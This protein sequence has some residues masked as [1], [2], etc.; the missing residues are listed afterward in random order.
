[1]RKFSLFASFVLAVPLAMLSQ[2]YRGA[3]GG[4]VTDPTGAVVTGAKVTVTETQTGTKVDTVS[5]NAG[6]YVAPFL[7]PGDYAIAVN[8]AGFKEFVR[9]GVHVGAGEHP[10]I[11]IRLEVG[12]ATQSVEVTADAGM[13]NTEN[14]SAGQAIS[15]REVDDLP[16]NGG[17]PL[18]MAALSLGVI[19]TGQPGLIHPF[20]SGGAA[21]WSV[22]GGYAQTSELL[23]DGSPDATWDGRLAYSLP[24]DAVEEV[25]I[26]A[27]DSDASYGHTGGGT[28]NQIMKTGTNG[29]HG[30]VYE[31]VQ[32]N[33]L[34]A[35]NF[36]NN[37]KGVPRPVTHYNQYGV[38]AGGPMLI[39]RVFDG[40]NKL[41]WFFAF[42]GLKDA[43]PN[44]AF[45]TVPT[46]AEKQ[47]N[48]S[49][50]L[51]ADGTILYDPR[52]A[53]A[54]GSATTR[55]A[56]P[57]N[58]IPTT[59]L[60]PVALA[61]LKYYPEPNVAPTKADGTNNFANSATTNDNYNN[62]LGRLD[63]NMTGRSRIFFDI[64]RTGYTQIKND[65]FDNA[66]Q[67]SLLF[68]NNWGGTVDEI[69]AI[70]ATNVL[71]VRANFSRMAEIHSSPGTGVDPASLG[72]PSYISS[73]SEYLQMP[74]VSFANPSASGFQGMGYSATSAVANNKLPS[75]SAQ[76]FSSLNRIMGSHNLRF[77]VDLRQYRL[78]TYTVGNATGTFSFSAN[79]WVRAGSAAS[80]T[81]ALGQDFSEF[82]LGLPTSGS[83][84][85]STY[86]SWYSY[87]ASPFF[88][89]DWRIKR[90]LTISLGVRYDWNGPYHEKFGRTLNGF[91]FTDPS[92]LQSAAQAAY[93]KSPSTYLPAGAFNVL[94]GDT[95]A[96]PGNNAVYRSVSHI[97]SPRA[98]FAWTP[99][100]LHGRTVIRGGFGVFASPVVISNLAISGTYSTNPFIN[101]PGY[102]ATTTLTAPT[103]TALV[104]STTPT[105][106]NPFPAG[107]A[108]P[109]GSSA[110]LL[111]SVGGTASFFNP[112]MK[113]PY[114][115][116]WN[117]GLEHTLTQNTVLEVLYIG[118]H[119]LHVP[120]SYTQLNGIPRQ[121]LSTYGL[122][123]SNES[124]LTTT[125][126]DPFNGLIASGTP[127]GASIT[128]AQLLSHYPQFTTGDSATGWSGG[129]GVLEENDSV[130]SSYFD[131]LNIGIRHRLS[132]DLSFNVNYI[133]SRLIEFDSWLNDSDARPEKRVSPTDHP[134]RFVTTLVYSPP[135]HFHSHLMETIAGGWSVSAVY[136]YQTGQPLVWANGSSTSPG[137]YVY[138]GAPLN[139]DNRQVNG[140]AFDPAAF[141]VKSADAFNYHIRT[142]P[143]TFNNLRQDGINELDASIL[144]DFRIGEKRKF[145]LRGEFYNIP[146]HPV[147]AAPGTTASATAFG[148]ITA[149]SNLAR[150]VQLVARLYW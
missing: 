133:K 22:G 44:A 16:L 28:L 52:S 58:L 47:G 137:D 45:T 23:V 114:S 68:R 26:K 146:N 132:K 51:A 42:E 140:N 25:R 30:T 125:A 4:A 33:T 1:M 3:I 122:R 123:D 61:Y 96:S 67:G 116:R 97:V 124:Y 126:T 111:T 38:T 136:T 81:V 70:N 121:Y 77:G 13:L 107:L 91:D 64:R 135:L 117:V 75:Q 86:G 10:V 102:S 62:E 54:S 82:M 130:G 105:L 128:I 6:Q 119:A 73:S 89:D 94:G 72:F 118:N 41:F 55:T 98:G 101:Q 12:E 57:N 93:A 7:T 134:N 65:Y 131:S 71:D 79:T 112:D 56:Y 147:F 36:F 106:S 80:S 17:T 29:L 69:F 63:Y 21:G 40:R 27:F 139:L 8:M 60:S 95:F 150:T 24:K 9:K 76:L 88:Q 109:T 115:M 108:T 110:G 145:E 78:N 84:D 90:N 143:T 48:F 144:K 50:I 142:F 66:S 2:E 103:S 32:P 87:Y 18:A 20:D 141:D 15:T 46:D 99:D 83:Y 49:Q 43:Q 149:T 92:P 120:V 148:T 37:S 104:A 31:E 14:A 59:Q 113:T 85:L 127:S 35:N 74:I 19:A 11:D 138:L 129:S 34:A 39:P 53:V 100:A 5:D